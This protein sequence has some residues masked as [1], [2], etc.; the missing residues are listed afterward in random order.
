MKIEVV[1]IPDKRTVSWAELAKSIAGLAPG[2]AAKILIKDLSQ[3]KTKQSAQS[4]I[5][6]CLQRY[7]LSID[8]HT[9]GE[10]IYISNRRSDAQK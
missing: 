9:E 4:V 2:K 3:A 1:N 7:G 6:S 8:T 5:Y 10:Y